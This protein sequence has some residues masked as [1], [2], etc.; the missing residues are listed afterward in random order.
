MTTVFVVAGIVVLL[1]ATVF[2][3]GVMLP[4]EHHV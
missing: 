4:Q 3:I 1:I 2:G